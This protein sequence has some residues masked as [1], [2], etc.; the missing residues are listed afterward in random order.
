MEKEVELKVFKIDYYCDKCN[1]KLVFSGIT[2]GHPPI[3]KHSC[4]C[5]ETYWLDKCYPK[6]EYK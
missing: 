3:Y 2:T 4:K 6:I 1:K 5:G